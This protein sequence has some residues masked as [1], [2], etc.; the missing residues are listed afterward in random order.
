MLPTNYLEWRVF[1]FAAAGFK[2]NDD[3]YVKLLVEAF[4]GGRVTYA[5]ADPIRG[6]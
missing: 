4:T 5:H 2:Q 6:S 3:V 1:G